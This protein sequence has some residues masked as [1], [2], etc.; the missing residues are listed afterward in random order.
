MRFESESNREHEHEYVD[1]PLFSPERTRRLREIYIQTT[2][3][4]AGDLVGDPVDPRRTQSQFE[5]PSH[6]LTATKPVIPM[7]CYMVLSSD[8][9]A[10]AKAAGNPLWEAAM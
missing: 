4:D 8:P 1:P 9:Q 3:Q 7:H 10:Y 2:P 6:A 5:E